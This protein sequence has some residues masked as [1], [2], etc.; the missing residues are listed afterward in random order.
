MTK[1][2]CINCGE[3]HQVESLEGQV[4]DEHTKVKYTCPENEILYGST[5]FVDELKEVNQK[6]GELVV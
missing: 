2:K 3:F 4:G 5:R 6:D 1:V